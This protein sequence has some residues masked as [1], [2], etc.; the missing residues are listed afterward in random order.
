MFVVTNRLKTVFVRNKTIKFYKLLR[1]SD[2]LSRPDRGLSMGGVRKNGT[3][4][5]LRDP[6]SEGLEEKN[7]EGS[8]LNLADN[9]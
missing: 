2:F 5:T 6:L 7:L 8:T 9:C 3:F 4:G 1:T